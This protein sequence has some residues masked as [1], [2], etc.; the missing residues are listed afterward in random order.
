MVIS[1]KITVFWDMIYCTLLDVLEKSFAAIFMSSTLSM[2]T[3]SSLNC[4]Y[5]CTFMKSN[6]SSQCSNLHLKILSRVLG[7]EVK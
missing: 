1:G 4:Q 2:E 5:S 3:L 6:Q 7:C